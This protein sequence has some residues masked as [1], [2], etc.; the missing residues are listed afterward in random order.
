MPDYRGT[1]REIAWPDIFP[2]TLLLRSL[3]L[4]VDPRK[5]LLAAAG[6]FLTTAG[7]WLIA[8]AFAAL[9][10]SDVPT[11]MGAPVTA[12][13]PLAAPPA[14][15]PWAPSVS[16]PWESARAAAEA[17]WLWLSSPF[18]MLMARGITLA[19]FA[20]ALLAALWGL[21][22]WAWIGGAIT[23]IA[24]VELG[25]DE[26]LSLGSAMSHA[27]SRWRSYFAAPLMPL[28]L[29]LL[30]CVP[31][32]IV[33]LLMSAF[34]GGVL[35]AALAW[36]LVLL[37]GLLMAVVMVGLA[38]GWPLMWATI[39]V[40]ATDSFDAVSRSYSYVYQRPLHYL[41][42]AVVSLLL[43]LLGWTI[44]ATFAWAVLYLSHWGV[45][46][47]SGDARLEQVEVAAAMSQLDVAL[48]DGAMPPVYDNVGQRG[49]PLSSAGRFG[50]A[51]IGFWD[52]LVRLG[53]AAFGYSF[54]WTAATAMY[55]LLRR[56]ADATEMDEVF[57]EGREDD[58]GLPPLKTDA[59]GV[60]VL[61][62][63]VGSELKPASGNTSGS[64]S[65]APP[66]DAG[67]EAV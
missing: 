13:S 38:V 31:L 43:G 36:P 25:L 2:W 8:Q 51:L 18:R 65:T 5:V 10:S 22:V 28:V 9:D 63:D 34:D 49:E 54:F 59:A 40:D 44:A 61:A 39:S 52:G 37:A 64:Q 26:R 14:P 27:T 16:I 12:R 47:G 19:S 30:L 67:S 50:A 3:R 62:D 1:V 57:I 15:A 7:W 17:N 4:A 48:P 53:T 45:S 21:A 11:P 20:A 32:A 6:L 56:D 58:R 24:A 35:V 60:A 29:V 46:W 42:Y 23:R 41:C 66:A 55:L 33:G